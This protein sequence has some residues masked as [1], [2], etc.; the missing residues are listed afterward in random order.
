MSAGVELLTR[1]TTESRSSFSYLIRIPESRIGLIVWI[2]AGPNW[3]VNNLRDL[4]SQSVFRIFASR[5]R[6]DGTTPSS[7][8]VEENQVSN[9]WR[10]NDIKET[11]FTSYGKFQ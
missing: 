9:R 3:V 8:G 2:E 4:F 10:I 6:L 1:C 7:E 5:T 11:E